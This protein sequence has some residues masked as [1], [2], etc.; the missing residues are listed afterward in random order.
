MKQ[1]II[2]IQNRLASLPELKYIDI[3]WGQIDYYDQPP[4]KYPCALIEIRQA[5]YSNEG[6]HVQYGTVIIIL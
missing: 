5:D 2:D 1:L 3:D 4:V 6:Q